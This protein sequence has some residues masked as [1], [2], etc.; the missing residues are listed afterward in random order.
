MAHQHATCTRPTGGSACIGGH[1]VD[2]CS[3]PN[4]YN[5]QCEFVG[6]CRC[7]CHTGKTCD[8]CG[9]ALTDGS[10]A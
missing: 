1:L 7:R 2:Y 8:C 4:C 6:H 5:D 10:R 3:S 9:A